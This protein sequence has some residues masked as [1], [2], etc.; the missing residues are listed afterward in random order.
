MVYLYAITDRPDAPVPPIPGLDGVSLHILAHRDIGAAISPFS[1]GGMPPTENNL[2]L[3]EAVLEFLMADR[4]VLPVRFGT[5]LA[6][7]S[8]VRDA[9]EAR[10]ADFAADLERVRGR[11]ELGLRVLWN[12]DDDS[13]RI[14]K[15]ENS[16]CLGGRAYM[17]DRLERERKAQDRR[18]QAAAIADELDAPLVGL[19]AESVRRVLTTPR[20]LLTAAYLVE[21]DSVATFREKVEAIGAG[22]PEL[23]FLCTG[24]WPPF[25]FVN[26]RLIPDWRGNRG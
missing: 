16:M 25:N 17:L 6:D 14:A 18:R 10:Y 9:I 22:R 3:H 21:R 7:E 19:S 20:L 26:N 5:M 15:T 1:K 24:P 11:V 2:W 13:P 12:D 8:A 4:I 23:R